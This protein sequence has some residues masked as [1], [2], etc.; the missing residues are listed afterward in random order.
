[1]IA[2]E[3]TTTTSSPQE[4]AELLREVAYLIDEGYYCGIDPIDW[5]LTET[6]Y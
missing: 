5:G 4:M 2:I 3:I 1:M 6:D